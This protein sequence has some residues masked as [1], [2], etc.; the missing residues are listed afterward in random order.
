MSEAVP[1]AAEQVGSPEL[2]AV[3]VKLVALLVTG[4]TMPL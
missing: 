2:V 3:N 1:Q 4:F